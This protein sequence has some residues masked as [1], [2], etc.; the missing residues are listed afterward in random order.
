L[1]PGARLCVLNDVTAAGYRYLAEHGPDLCVVTVSS[2]IGHKVF[3]GGEP[4]LGPSARGGEIGH[5]RVDH[6]AEA[7][8]CDCGGHGHLASVAS[9]RGVLR[10][11]RREAAAGTAA[12]R[13]SRLWP[14]I[15]ADPSALDNPLLVRAFHEGDAWACGLID[16]AARELG[17][18]LAF[19]HLGVG[20]E[21][22]VIVGGLAM[23]LGEGYRQ[24]L[25]RAARETAWDRGNDWDSG[26]V[27]GVVE[28]AAGLVGAGRYAEAVLAGRLS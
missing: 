27:L 2:G 3:I 21:R 18:M 23:A 20:T 12:A 28:D 7:P 13:A 6:S 17:R 16:D 11:A 5:L 24:R 26:V 19:I 9:G 14:A 1:F 22:F 8:P 25:V 4:A 10:R 15:A